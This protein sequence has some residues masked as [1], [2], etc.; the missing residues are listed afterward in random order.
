MKNDEKLT[1][2]PSD[3]LI[4]CRKALH[5]TQKELAQMSGYTVQHLSRIERGKQRLTLETA[6]NLSKC[7]NVS[8]QYLLGNINL[9]NNFINTY[10]DFLFE[11]RN[12]LNGILSNFLAVHGIYIEEDLS[13]ILSA[14]SFSDSIRYFSRNPI[15]N[16]DNSSRTIKVRFIKPDSFGEFEYFDVPAYKISLLL[17]DIMRISG[18]FAHDF[19]LEISEKTHSHESVDYFKNHPEQFLK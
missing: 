18:Y 11:H 17:S 3:R 10:L 9:K 19:R 1:C 5:L 15:L 12:N 2:K 6:E 16:P 8:S 14:E 13:D 4:E 7:L